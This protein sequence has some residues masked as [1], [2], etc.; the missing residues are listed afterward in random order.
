VGEVFEKVADVYDVMNDVMSA[1]I[2]RV[3]YAT[4][5]GST[6]VL[7]SL[8]VLPCTSSSSTPTPHTHT[9]THTHRQTDRQTDTHTHRHTQTETDT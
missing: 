4:P 6:R 5:T 3:W 8:I 2:H 1:G 7:L 9:H